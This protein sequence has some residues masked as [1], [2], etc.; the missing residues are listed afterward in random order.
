MLRGPVEVNY[1]CRHRVGFGFHHNIWAP[2]VAVNKP[3]VSEFRNRPLQLIEDQNLFAGCKRT[4]F[5]M[6]GVSCDTFHDDGN[7]VPNDAL[8]YKELWRESLVREV[9]VCLLAVSL[10][11]LHD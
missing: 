8:A 4:M 2:Q 11:E 3:F 7:Q 10:H 9:F 1:F 6:Q 5:Y